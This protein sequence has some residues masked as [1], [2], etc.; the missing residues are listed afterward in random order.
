MKLTRSA[1]NPI[2]RPTDKNDWE[3]LGVLNPA[4]WYEDGV[5]YLLYR[6]AGDDD[7]QY[8]ILQCCRIHGRCS[9]L[10]FGS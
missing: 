4:A 6:A 1:N 9:F 7:A 3:S 8:D 10:S 2:L 5:F